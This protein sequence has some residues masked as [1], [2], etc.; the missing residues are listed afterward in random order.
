MDALIYTQVSSDPSGGGRS[1]ADQERECRQVCE[2]NG[3]H[4][5]RVYTDNDRGASRYS[6]DRPAGANSRPTS[7]RAKYS[8]VGKRAG[9]PVT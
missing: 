3:W 4:V 8:C 1:V 9:R 2:R 5:R 6:G 7:E